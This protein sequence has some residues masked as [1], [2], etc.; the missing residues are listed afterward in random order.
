MK[1]NFNTLE[2]KPVVLDV[3]IRDGGYLNQWFF[4]GEQMQLAFDRALTCG[5]DIIE[6]GYLD[7]RDGLP[8][9]ASW[10]SGE[11]EKLQ[12]L[13]SRG[14]LAAMCRP[15]V[16]HAEKVLAS[17]KEMIDLVRIPVDL[18]NPQL[19]NH[20]AAMCSKTGLP[21]TFNLTN[22][23]C[24]SP[25]QISSA[26][27]VLS[28]EAVAVYIADSRGALYPE[29]IGPIFDTLAAVRQAS[30][31]YHAH[32]NLGLAAENTRAALQW[33]VT[34]IDGSLL[35]IGLGGRN[36]TLDDA[37]TLAQPSRPNL[38]YTKIDP[39]LSEPDFGVPPRG[40]EMPMYRLTGEK[41]FKMEWAMMMAA[42]LGQDAACRIIASLPE[43][44][45]FLPEELKPFV[46]IEQWNQLIW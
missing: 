26:F 39:A 46:T 27:S 17:R 25:G 13:R 20:L 40:P 6:I 5:A 38:P 4:T 31:G 42:Q 14:L 15:S 28:D 12:N 37:L 32:D 19:A 2:N 7:D 44:I 36:L 3:T 23:S 24:F 11:L 41:N 35:G 33:G 1:F 8:V 30:F 29:Q 45:L 18:R 43:Q 22:I 34:W 10:L 9:A 16:L 21:Y